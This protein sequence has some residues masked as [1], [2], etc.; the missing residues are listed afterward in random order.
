LNPHPLA[1]TSPSSWRVCLFRHSD[2]RCPIDAERREATA[3]SP[4][5]RGPCQLP[6]T[7]EVV[8]GGGLICIP[9]CE[10]FQSAPAHVEA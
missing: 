6:G 8:V 2:K 7:V 10:A 4:V 3:S 9:H 5:G 1:W